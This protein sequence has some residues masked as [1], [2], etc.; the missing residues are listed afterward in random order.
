MKKKKKKQY[1]ALKQSSLSSIR[2]E[3][4]LRSQGRRGQF[5]DN[6]GQ[7]PA[8]VG[9]QVGGEELIF[10]PQA[11]SDGEHHN[12]QHFLQN[13]TEACHPRDILFIL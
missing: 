8:G 1:G 5:T 10:S 4:H 12:Y 3:P 9:D 13:F 2:T 11:V 7:Q 6:A